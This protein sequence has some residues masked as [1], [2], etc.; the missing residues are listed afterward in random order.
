MTVDTEQGLKDYLRHKISGVDL[1][2]KETITNITVLLTYTCPAACDHC[3]FESSPLRRETIDVE[4]ARR[5][6]EAASRQQPPPA[7]DARVSPPQHLPLS[8][9]P[10]ESALRDRNRRHLGSLPHR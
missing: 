8:V 9:A 6:I 3:L 10:H 4:M 1:L 5:F 2:N 7:P